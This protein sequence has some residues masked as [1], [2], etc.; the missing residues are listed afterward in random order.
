MPANQLTAR[1]RVLKLIIAAMTG[2]LFA[3]AVIVVV[4]ATSGSM[5]AHLDLAPIMMIVLCGLAV[6]E[7]VGYV[8]LRQGIIAKTRGFL[9]THSD[10]GAPAAAIANAFATLTIVAGAMLEGLGL[11][12]AVIVLVT[13]DE[14]ALAAPA[15]A[16]LLLLAFVLPNEEK[17]R[18]FVAKITA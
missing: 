10:F 13:G 7:A 15:V 2:G 9:R 11:F 8:V 5:E 17:A 4:L 3:F 1:L 14:L 12:G 16:I 6:C 18:N